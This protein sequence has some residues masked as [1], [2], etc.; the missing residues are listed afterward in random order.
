MDLAG[1]VAETAG[2]AAIF[3]DLKNG[4]AAV[5]S[6]V[7]D[8][9]RANPAVR[10]AASAQRWSTLRSLDAAT[11]GIG[12]Y[13]SIDVRPQLNLFLSLIARDHRPRGVSCRH[14]LL[15]ESMVHEMHG[16]QLEVIAWTVDEPERAEELAS[17]GIDGITTN[18]VGDI[19]ARLRP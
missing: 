8:A 11:R 9:V 19:V 4:G 6:L 16:H 2:S 13:Y 12:L 7:A 1:L 10:I 15:T 5:G 17:W 3:L 14:T 18:R